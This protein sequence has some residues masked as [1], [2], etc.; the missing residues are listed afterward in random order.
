MVVAWVRGESVK[1]P[2]RA[3]RFEDE[4]EMTYECSVVLGTTAK[5]EAQIKSVKVSAATAQGGGGRG[6]GNVPQP[7]KA[8]GGGVGQCATIQTRL[9]NRGAAATC[10]WEASWEVAG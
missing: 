5:G 4:P 3:D 1:E 8:D 2:T 10:A 6:T 7:A 9:A